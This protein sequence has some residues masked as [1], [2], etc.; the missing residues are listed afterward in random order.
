MSYAIVLSE[1]LCDRRED[2]DES[3]CRCTLPLRILLEGGCPLIPRR[4]FRANFRNGVA[5]P[6]L[7]CEVHLAKT[8]LQRR[9][10]LKSIA[11]QHLSPLEIEKF[12]LNRP[13][14]LDIYAMQVDEILRHRAIIQ[15]GPLSTYLDEDF[16]HSQSSV[17][18]CRS[19]YHELSSVEDANLYFNLG[20]HD[21]TARLDKPRTP[22]NG[23]FRY[24][25]LPF[26][27]WLLSRGAPLY[28][29]V[30]HWRLPWTGFV[31]DGFVL[32]VL[33]DKET[34]NTRV[35]DD[36]EEL[37]CEL[38]EHMLFD[39]SVDSCRCRC[40]PGGCTPFVVRMKVMGLLGNELDIA[41][42]ITAYLRSTATFCKGST[43]TLRYGSSPFR[44]LAL[45]ILAIVKE[46]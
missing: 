30:K 27:K 43:V 6:S 46:I 17:E 5:H 45:R 8:L 36:D 3:S 34:G 1:T 35:C 24:M 10:E 32:S 23:S 25:S 31:A 13:V 19:I 4:D 44:R 7:H 20:F 29:W 28:E 2:Q 33:S 12:S 14:V 38:E 11:Q 41:T 16:T 18:V 21:L 40:S 9:Q 15:F 39:D 37:V 42:T 26:V 22:G